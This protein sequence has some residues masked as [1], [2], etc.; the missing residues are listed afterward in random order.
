MR[1]WDVERQ[2]GDLS[3]ACGQERGV[4]NREARNSTQAIRWNYAQ[5]S[6]TA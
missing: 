4:Q 2:K 6:E 3:K 1:P 5:P